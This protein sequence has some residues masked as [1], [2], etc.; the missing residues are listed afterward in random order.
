MIS[1]VSK[2]VG[3]VARAFSRQLGGKGSLC[4]V[5][6]GKMPVFP[7]Q[8]FISTVREEDRNVINKLNVREAG[9]FYVKTGLEE[10]VIPEQYR[11]IVTEARKELIALLSAER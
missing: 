9:A 8:S 1:R 11:E 5:Y 7:F 3:G 2:G 4:L 10:G 6:P